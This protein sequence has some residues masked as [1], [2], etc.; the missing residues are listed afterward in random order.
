MNRAIIPALAIALTLFLPGGAMAAQA[1]SGQQTDQHDRNDTSGRHGSHGSHGSGSTNTGGG[2]TGGS[3]TTGGQ[4]GG[5]TFGGSQQGAGAGTTQ[6]TQ[7]PAHTGTTHKRVPA[8]NLGTTHTG[9]GLSGS[10]GGGQNTIMMQGT[11][12]SGQTG[13][14]HRRGRTGGHVGQTPFVGQPGQNVLQ[15]FRTRPQNW[16]RY[17]H[18]FDRRVYQRNYNAQ[19]RYRW[20]RYVRPRGWY[21]RRWVFG[22]FFPTF[23]WTS[24]YRIYDYWMF[25]LPIP[26][27][28]YVW[29]RYGDDAV[30]VNEWTGQILQVVY[31]LFD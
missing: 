24:Q 23:F 5:Y 6:G 21:Y 30:L 18:K 25:G 26:P 22:D 20:H 17:P 2:T 28:G 8:G 4:G 19:H 1:G 11:Q 9:T 14:V 31:G 16:N 29:V 27:Y 15:P 13:T 12:G 10:Q 3:H 7:F